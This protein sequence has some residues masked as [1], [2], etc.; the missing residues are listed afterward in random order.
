[1]SA[2]PGW[3]LMRDLHRVGVELM[4]IVVLHMTRVSLIGSSATCAVLP[5]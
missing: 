1:M 3:Q 5:G 2:I 4:K